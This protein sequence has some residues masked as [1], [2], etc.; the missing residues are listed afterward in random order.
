MTTQLIYA[1][2][3]TRDFDDK[4]LSALLATCVRNNAQL[5]ITGLLLYSQG[6]FLQVLEGPDAAVDDIMAR[7]TADPRHH[8]VDTLLRSDI[9]TRDFSQWHMGFRRVGKSDA[10][11]LPRYAPFF[12]NGFDVRQIGA[13]P[14]AS[15]EIMKAL[16]EVAA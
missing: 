15:L 12:E 7:V 9:K 10:L 5:D 13:R 11:A 1:S 6:T 8:Q 14:D 2:I 16:L 4:E 3:A